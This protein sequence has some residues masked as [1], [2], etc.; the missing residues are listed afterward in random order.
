[1]RYEKIEKCLMCNGEGSVF[2]ATAP[3]GRSVCNKCNGTGEIRTP[4]KH[5]EMW[6]VYRGNGVLVTFGESKMDAWLTAE[7]YEYGLRAQTGAKGH[8]LITR[9]KSKGYTCEQIHVIRRNHE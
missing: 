3:G 6:A 2:R 5:I 4:V 7:R 9:L 1:M 8:E